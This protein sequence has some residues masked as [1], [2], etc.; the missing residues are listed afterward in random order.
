MRFETML[1]HAGGHVDEETGALAP[2][3]HLSTTFERD[4]EGGPSRGFSYVRDGNP[5]QARLEEALAAIDEGAAS[6][7]FASG[8]AAGAALLQALPHGTHVV[9]PDDC[10]Y[11]FRALAEESFAKWGLTSAVVAMED[12]DAVRAAMRG[13]ANVLWA[14]SPSNPL[15]KIVDL[16]ALAELAHARGARLVVDGTFATPALQRPLALGADVVLHSTTKYL[17]G[18]SDVQGGALVFAKHD[19]LYAVT[20]RVREL[21]GGVASPFNAWL[22]LRGL[23]TLAAR[24][25]VHSENAAAVAEFLAAQPRVEAVFYP[26][27]ASHPRHDVARKQMS[28]FGGMLSFLVRGGRS[29]ALA[30]AAKTRLFTRATSLGGVESLIEHRASSEGPASRTPQNLLRVSVG[31]EHPQDLVDDLRNAL[32]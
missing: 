11:G 20:E 31:L 24:M 18:H 16:A 27:L 25:R 32:S 22:I 1:V 6:L 29:E 9:L 2:P 7:A 30:V 19:A 26:G 10:Y 28:A 23:R 21:V 12:L 17:G 4:V 13:D 8:M 3:I 15:M 5:T 14:E